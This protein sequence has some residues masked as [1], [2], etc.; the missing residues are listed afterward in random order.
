MEG[1]LKSSVTEIR[2]YAQVLTPA[3]SSYHL[4]LGSRAGNGVTGGGSHPGALA[5]GPDRSCNYWGVVLR[6][7]R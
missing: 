3:G 1:N 2:E 4:G 6:R 7:R 5:E